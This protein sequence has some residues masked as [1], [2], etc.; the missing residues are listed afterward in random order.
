MSFD[1][2]FFIFRLSNVLRVNTKSL[3][4]LFSGLPNI[5]LIAI[6]ADNYIYDEVGSF[7]IEIRF[8]NTVES[9]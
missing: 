3:C 6:A 2:D 9:L 4:R 8:Q 5:F 7:A 1:F